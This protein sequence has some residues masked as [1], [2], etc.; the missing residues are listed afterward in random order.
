MTATVKL[1]GAAALLG[2]L[3][4]WW[5][6]RE[7]NAARFTAGAVGA[8]EGAASGAV[9]GVGQVFGVPATSASKCRADLDAGNFWASSFSC[10]A[11]DFVGGI[12]NSTGI[13]QAAARDY[14]AAVA[15]PSGALYDEARGGYPIPIFPI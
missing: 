6:T 2:L 15:D 1:Y 10:P 9:V 13:N 11:L 5:F 12:W 7:G 3:G 4:L 14:A 8:A